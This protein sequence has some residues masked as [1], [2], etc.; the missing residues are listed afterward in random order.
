MV[1][2]IFFGFGS[3]LGDKERNIECAYEKIEKRI[4]NI[5]SRSAFYVSKP[6]GFKSAH[7]FVNSACEVLSEMDIDDIFSMTQLIEKE[8]GR[9]KKSHN[10]NYSDR[11]IDID[12]LLADNLII[13]APKLT[14][15]HPRLHQRKFVLEPLAEIV[16]DTIHPVFHKTILQLKN[17][18]FAS[19]DMPNS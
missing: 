13:N 19:P 7:L 4:G 16:P 11:I 8:I 1:H 2:R 5:V 3:N 9:T 18:L 14:I 12:L 17:E 6:Q 10:G 15:P